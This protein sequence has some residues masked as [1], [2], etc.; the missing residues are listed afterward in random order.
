MAD[1]TARKLLRALRL[2]ILGVLAIAMLAAAA[3]IARYL[4]THR[5][6]PQRTPP[7]RAVPVVEV[8]PAVIADELVVVPAMGTVIPAVEITLQAQVAGRITAIH[9]QF[10]EGGLVSAGDVL[11]EIEPD[12]FEL[13][14]TTAR[15]QLA[16][17]EAN[18]AIEQ[19]QQAVARRE[20]ELLDMAEG[21]SEMDLDLALRQPYLRQRQAAVEAA[22]AQVAAAELHLERTRVTVPGNAVVLSADADAGDLAAAQRQ[23]AH[24]AGTDAFWVLAAVPVDDL[25]W[26]DFTEDETPASRVRVNSRASGAWEGRLLRLLGDLED[27]GRMARVLIEV[28]DPLRR[29]PDAPEGLPLLLGEFVQ[30]EIAGRTVPAVTRLDREAVHNGGEVWTVDAENRL[31]VA[32]PE[33]VWRGQDH[34]LVRGLAPGTPVVVS[35]LAAPVPG[36]ELRVENGG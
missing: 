12:D 6:V 10:I 31:A 2:L 22:R 20:W 11:V 4:L 15:S 7:P 18:L 5:P 9:P 8:T 17:A 21:A 28:R 29:A 14:L 25:H 26:L 19:G 16:T 33:I 24:L 34:V 1:T 32:T 35:V 27:R 23:L 3:G 30:V 13:A 36:M